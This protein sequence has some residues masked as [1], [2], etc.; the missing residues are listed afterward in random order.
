M[1]SLMKENTEAKHIRNAFL[2]V[3]I[4]NILEKDLW[5]IED[6]KKKL[7]RGHLQE[8]TFSF[9]PHQVV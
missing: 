2:K 7:Q 9:F 8:F 6:K 4:S 3:L 1:Q 5:E